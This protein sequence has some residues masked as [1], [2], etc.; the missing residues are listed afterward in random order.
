MF[1]QRVFEQR[2]VAG[3]DPVGPVAWRSHLFGLDAE[4][5][6]KTRREIDGVV[7]DVP[8][9]EVFVD[10]FERERIALGVRQYILRRLGAGLALRQLGP[11][12]PPGPLDRSG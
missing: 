10:G 12:E 7:D 1:R 4:D 6:E 9:V 11:L 3:M 8:V 5:I 2:L